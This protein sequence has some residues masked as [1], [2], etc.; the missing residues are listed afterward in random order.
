MYSPAL[1]RFL[2][3]DPVGYKDGLNWYAYVGNDP[4]NRSD[5]TG[6][7]CTGSGD[8]LECHIDKV[9]LPKGTTLS[10]AQKANISSFNQ[11]YTN[12]VKTLSSDPNKSVSVA[13]G[14]KTFD[15]KAGDVAKTLAGRTFVAKPNE[16]GTAGTV[17]NT[18]TVYSQGLAGTVGPSQEHGQ[19]D[20]EITIAHEG[21][22]QGPGEQSVL[23][24]VDRSTVNP[25][26]GWPYD[27]ATRQ[28]LGLPTVP[29]Y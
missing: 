12:T 21:I 3:T 1:G 20:R 24:G 11:A 2:Q 7:T 14:G 4:V 8:T 28:L 25:A 10:D 23:P 16:A 6:K 15:V 22:H 18:T 9:D 27:N 19:M 17:R 13:V 5:R 26:H 29:P